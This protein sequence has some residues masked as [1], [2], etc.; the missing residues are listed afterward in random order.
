MAEATLIE[1]SRKEGSW[2]VLQNCHLAES[3]MVRA[4]QRDF[5]PF[6]NKLIDGVNA[7][8]HHRTWLPAVRRVVVVSLST[9]MPS[10]STGRTR[11]LGCGARRAPRPSS[12]RPYCRTAS[13]WLLSR[14]KGLRANLV[15][16]YS[17]AP[18]ANPGYLESNSKPEKF[19]K[20]CYSLCIFH[21][22]LQEK[23]V[24]S[25]RLVRDAVLKLN[26]NLNLI[27]CSYPHRNIPYGFNE[28]DMLIS[29]Q[30]LFFLR[31]K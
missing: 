9:L 31:R 27:D 21:A 26:L 6:P 17:A 18:I 16:S 2:V 22:L 11:I 25:A 8:P 15:G 14:P 24:W 1:K 19:R 28:S 13:R 30:Q 29:L 12:R 20:L 23:I 7:L 5:Q 4:A 10:M 3:F